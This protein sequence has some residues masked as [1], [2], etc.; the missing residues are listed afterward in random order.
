MP[1]RRRDGESGIKRGLP[2]EPIAPEDVAQARM[3]PATHAGGEFRLAAP[4]AAAP[5]AAAA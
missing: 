3:V 5:L 1:P 2:V 4:G